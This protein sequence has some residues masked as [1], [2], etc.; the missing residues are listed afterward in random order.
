MVP[1]V[2]GTL[3]LEKGEKNGEDRFPMSLDVAQ[4]AK[5][6]ILSFLTDAVR[7]WQKIGQSGLALSAILLF[8]TGL[9]YYEQIMANIPPWWPA[10]ITF[11]LLLTWLVV[12]APQR[13]FIE[14]A[15][16]L[17]LA[18]R[19]EE[20]EAYFRL[21]TAYN[22]ILQMVALA[23]VLLLFYPFF[24]DLVQAPGQPGWGYF[25]LPLVLKGWNYFA[26]WTIL[27][28]GDH[29]LVQWSVGVR[30]LFSLAVLLWWFEQGPA[31]LL[32]PFGAA[33]V[34]FFLAERKF[35]SPS[36]WPWLLFLELDRRQK[37]R[38]YAFCQAFVDV[39]HIV[40]P[41]RRRAWLEGLIRLPFERDYAF[42]FLQLYTWLRSPDYFGIYVRLTL[43]GMLG[44]VLVDD[45]WSR[46]MV[47]GLVLIITGIQLKGMAYHRRH[48]WTRL[49]PLPEGMFLE[50][51]HWLNHR[52]LAI[53][54]TFLLG[55]ILLTG[56][57][58]LAGALYFL[59]AQMLILAYF[60]AK[61]KGQMAK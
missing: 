53:Q 30:A 50:S 46:G 5:G 22:L 26:H 51:H 11:A 31:W 33:G 7:Y 15:D 8:L 16:L 47:Y 37:S 1:D 45:L 17:F 48:L 14:E 2:N 59:L 36:P 24:R 21:T 34:G 56:K 43:L 9:I 19:E 60:W 38:F 42:R 28:R 55:A 58:M 39:P 32:L 44:I 57:G 3:K 25:L 61:K 20:M 13:H 41:A 23:V 40:R 52:L 10:G 18:P 12:R 6:R 49:F 35:S 29:T 4:V 27:R 54:A